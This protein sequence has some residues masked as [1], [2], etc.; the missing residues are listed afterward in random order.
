[1]GNISI[2]PNAERHV[3]NFVRR[4]RNRRSFVEEHIVLLNVL[5]MERKNQFGDII[6]TRGPFVSISLETSIER[7]QAQVCLDNSGKTLFLS[8][9]DGLAGTIDVFENR[10]LNRQEL[11]LF[12]E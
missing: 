8:G 9:F 11:R 6:S 2:T 7:D 12:S 4:I 1:M 10:E 3:L 5:S